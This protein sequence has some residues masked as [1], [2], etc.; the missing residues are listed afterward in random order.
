MKVKQTKN[1]K[2]LKHSKFKNVLE[3]GSSPTLLILVLLTKIAKCTQEVLLAQRKYDTF[4]F[5]L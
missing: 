5:S 3:F 1:A 4:T 2:L